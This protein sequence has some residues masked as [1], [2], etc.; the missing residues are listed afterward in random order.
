MPLNFKGDEE[1]SDQQGSKKPILHQPGEVNQGTSKL[2]VILLVV[3]VLAAG[4]FFVYKYD[5][6][7]L[8]KTKQPAVNEPA[9]KPAPQH[10]EQS[11]Q[12]QPPVDSAQRAHDSVMPQSKPKA[13]ERPVVP[14]SAGTYTIYISRHKTKE[15][16]DAEAAK[17]NQAGYETTV[18]EYEGWYRV[19]IGRYIT[20]DEAKAVAEKLKD[21]FEA[22]YKIGKVQE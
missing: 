16:A 4:G 12:T 20:W 6:L 1:T 11:P 3:A 10:P 21:G 14:S 19:S 5:V 15:V 2:I 8:R 9:E 17:W 13:E 7:R 18:T 22:G